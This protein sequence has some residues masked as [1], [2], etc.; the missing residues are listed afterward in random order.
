MIWLI[1]FSP[2]DS[3]DSYVTGT[4]KIYEPAW[5]IKKMRVKYFDLQYYWKYKN[6]PF[7]EFFPETLIPNYKKHDQLISDE[8][9][10]RG[11]T[12]FLALRGEK[13]L[14]RDRTEL[15]K[16]VRYFRNNIEQNN[17]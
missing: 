11:Y 12:Q 16:F 8:H 4:I 1:R 7:E 17:N 14:S 2:G 3:R 15:K 10:L 9:S 5:F 13:L 6:M